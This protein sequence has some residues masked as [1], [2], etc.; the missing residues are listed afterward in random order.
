MY[1]LDYE[2]GLR[3]LAELIE[4]QDHSLRPEF[5]TL[6]ARLLE[7]Q[8][9]ERLFG[10]HPSSNATRAEIIYALNQ[11]TDEHF[12]LSF[13]QLCHKEESGLTEQIED[14][15][16]EEPT[17]RTQHI[18]HWQPGEVVK[19]G[20]KAYI[21]QEPIELRWSV[22]QSV[23]QQRAPA[24]EERFG[25]RVFIKQVQVLRTTAS[26]RSWIEAVQKEE[27]LL[28]I[29]SIEQRRNFPFPLDSRQDKTTI[30]L[31][32]NLP[33]GQPLT[34]AIGLT[35]QPLE[36]FRTRALLRSI[37]TLGRMLQ[38]LHTHRCSHREITPDAIFLT[39]NRYAYLRDIGLATYPFTRGEGP[40][41]YRAP[42]QS[43]G[44]RITTLPGTR[45]DIYQLG[46]VLY[47]LLTGRQPAK[48]PPPLSSWNS[49]IT[50]ELDAILLQAIAEDPQQRWKTIAAFSQALQKA[51]Q[52][53]NL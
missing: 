39:D 33:K 25:T 29:L 3:R 44:T 5:N 20:Q 15:Q 50:P 18:E 27:R 45:T 53:N 4:A 48:T 7:Q 32:T 24:L 41:D 6:Q 17:R 40:A 36:A 21:V 42:E 30:T 12:A 28:H 47:R 13:L 16:Q 1:S 8:S 49:A 10:E 51:L 2:Q 11:F 9:K 37:S 34:Q 14:N 26:A 31:V 19:V 35:D 23:L 43:S 46:L 38:T 52:Q 22:D